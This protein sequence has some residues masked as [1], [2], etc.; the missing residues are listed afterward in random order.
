MQAGSPAEEAGLSPQEDFILAADDMIFESMEDFGDYLEE[1]EGSQ[2]S[3]FVYN[4]TRDTVRFV[5]LVLSQQ[6]WGPPEKRQTGLGACAI[7]V[8]LLLLLSLL[9]FLVTAFA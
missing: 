2:V 5:S 3:F 9:L 1:K 6:E 7:R 8:C 4:M